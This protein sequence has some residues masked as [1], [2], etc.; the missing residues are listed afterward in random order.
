M[1]IIQMLP[2]ISYGDAVSNDTIAISN[3]L[4]KAGYKTEIYAVSV[5]VRLPKGIAKSIDHFRGVKKDDLIIYHLSTGSKLNWDFGKLKCKKVIIYHNITPPKYLEKYSAEAAHICSEGLRSAKW[6]AEE[7]EVDYII[8]ASEYNKADLRELGFKCK[9]DVLPIVIPFDDYKKKPNEYVLRR[10]DDSYVNILFTGRISPNKCQEDVIKTFYEY[11]KKYNEKSRLI[12]VGS[13]GGYENYKKRLVNYCNLLGLTEDDVIFPG[14]IRF[15]E[16]L[17]YYKLADVFLCMSEHEGF[18]VPLV[19]AML[20]DTPII[21]YDSS[22]IYSTL[23]GSGILL[24]KKNPLEAAAMIDY[25]MKHDDLKNTVIENQKERL[26]DFDN[27][28]IEKQL[29]KL[30]K[31]NVL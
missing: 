18:C 7:G 14:H 5:D 21:A 24:K 8:A 11:K 27:E 13:S 23:G 17:A 28:K 4:K 25:L 31:E 9:I 19:E 3:T 10:Y 26:K 22:A 30:L 20:F 1:K 16:I 15:D 12:L 6:L 2:T 29:M